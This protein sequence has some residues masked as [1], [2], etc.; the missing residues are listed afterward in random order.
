MGSVLD[1]ASVTGTMAAQ[2]R[3]ATDTTRAGGLALMASSFVLSLWAGRSLTRVLAA[4]S[5]G[6]WRIT[7][8]ASRATL[9]MAGTVTGLVTALILMLAFM[10]R[11]REDFSLPFATT[12]WAAT[13][14]VLCVAWFV[15]S[16]S[17]P[18]GTTDPGALLPGAAL[19]GL[20]L[21]ALQWV[22]QYYLPGRI[23]R[24]SDLTGSLGI[25]IAALGYLFLIGRVMASSLILNAVVFERI[26]SVTGLL[27]ALPVLRRIPERSP[28]LAHF[29]DVERR[30]G[31]DATPAGA[32]GDLDLDAGRRG[33]TEA[34]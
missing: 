10:N 5:A 33:A 32:A 28:R 23:E 16:W 14:V 20:T 2:I 17:L 19:T 12:S 4:C 26:G 25:T 13:A 22:M 31:A 15:V 21:T 7:G 29:F 3:S 30:P 6:A 8:R 9:R 18:R 24:A 27:F 1:S 34:R 11:V